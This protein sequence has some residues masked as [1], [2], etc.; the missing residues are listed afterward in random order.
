MFCLPVPITSNLLPKMILCQKTVK[1]V[2]FL[3][4]VKQI[5]QKR[6]KM[7]VPDFIYIKGPFFVT[8]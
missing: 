2:F 1:K 7:K 3:N 5:L 6:Q 4:L 8:A